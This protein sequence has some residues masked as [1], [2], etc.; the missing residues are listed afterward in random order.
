MH[1]ASTRNVINIIRFK[2]KT[3]IKA[4]WLLFYSIQLLQITIIIVI[5][6]QFVIHASASTR[7]Y[8]SERRSQQPIETMFTYATASIIFILKN[9]A[10]VISEGF[11]ISSFLFVQVI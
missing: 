6:F 7:R 2:T 8:L 10:L 3:P 5:N 9:I 4:I 11:F 1:S